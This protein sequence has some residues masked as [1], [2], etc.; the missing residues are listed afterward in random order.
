MI[1]PAQPA[2]VVCRGCQL[3]SFCPPSTTTMTTVVTTTLPGAST[4][5]TTAITTTTTTA[6]PLPRPG[7]SGLALVQCQLAAALGRP[8][9]GNEVV[10]PAVDHALRANLNAANAAL[11]SATTATGRKGKSSASGPSAI[12]ERRADAPRGRSRRGTQDDTCRRRARGRSR[13]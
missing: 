1:V 3:L 5:T 10:P 2:C 7:L 11:C 12:S 4:T 8:L 9:C 13:V 6:P